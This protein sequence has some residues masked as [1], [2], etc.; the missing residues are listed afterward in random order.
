M[1][2][3]TDPRHWDNIISNSKYSVSESICF[4]G[5]SYK[6][7]YYDKA[8]EL[9]DYEKGYFEA[10]IEIANS[11]YGLP[12][13]EEAIN[14][15]AATSLLKKCDIAIPQYSF[16]TE[17]ELAAYI[18]EQKLT[19]VQRTNLISAIADKYMVTVYSGHNDWNHKNIV[20]K[21][22]ADY[23]TQMP[24]I[25]NKSAINLNFTLRSIHSGIPLRVLDILACGGFCLSNYQSDIADAFSDEEIVMFDSEEDLLEKIDYYMNNPDKRKKIATSGKEKIIRYFTYEYQIKK[26][27]ET[28]I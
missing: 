8:S 28:I 5:S 3:A 12:I 15:E 13:I 22:R 20:F 7:T 1:P 17:K 9:S 25:F 18:L 6:D 10:L 24:V 23:E 2:L 19:S 4:L 11:L 27:F 26:M 14:N 16:L 21:G